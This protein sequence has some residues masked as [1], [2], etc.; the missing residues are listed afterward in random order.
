MASEIER[1]SFLDY[2]FGGCEIQL[3]IAIDFT[4]SNGDP[5]NPTSHHYLDFGIYIYI[6][7]LFTMYI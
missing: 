6:Y 5:R 1:P 3:I 2:I 7:N 4:G